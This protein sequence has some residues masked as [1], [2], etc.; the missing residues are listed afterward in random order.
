MRLTL[1]W[2]VVLDTFHKPYTVPFEREF[3][4]RVVSMEPKFEG[5]LIL[6]D[7][8][9]SK[10][11]RQWWQEVQD[12]ADQWGYTAYDLTTIGHSSGTALLD[13]SGKVV[14]RD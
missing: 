1:T 3:L 13:F 10:E 8:Y 2:L 7:I 14:I 11:M 6:D 4:S 5:I 12:N 9:H